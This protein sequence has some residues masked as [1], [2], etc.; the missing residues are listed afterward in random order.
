M[1][2]AIAMMLALAAGC[3]GTECPPAQ[4][5]WV[6]PRFQYPPTGEVVWHDHLWRAVNFTRA[7]PGAYPDWTDLGCASSTVP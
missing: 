1:R 2:Y 7:E 6:G 3:G 5:T 4:S